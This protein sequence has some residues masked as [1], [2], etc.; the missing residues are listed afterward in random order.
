MSKNSDDSKKQPYMYI[1]QPE[2]SPPPSNMQSHFRSAIDQK[3]LEIIEVDEGTSEEISKDIHIVSS[4]K[5]NQANN[6]VILEDDPGVSTMDQENIEEVVEVSTGVEV[7]AELELNSKMKK[8][9]K[10]KLKQSKKK[11]FSDM[12]KEELVAFLAKIPMAVPKPTC[13]ISIRGQRVTGQIHR[14]KGDNYF[15]KILS[16]EVSETVSIKIEDI[17]FIEVENL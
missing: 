11:N 14:K 8:Q 3:E 5:I 15:V 17:D 6:E 7:E 2:I 9:A 4:E 10:R 12:T 13:S 1:V 16:D